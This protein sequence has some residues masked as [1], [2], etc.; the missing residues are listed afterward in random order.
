MARP[1]QRQLAEAV[2][3]RYPRS[4]ADQLGLG[5]PSGASGLFQLLTMALLMSARIRA[6]IA[7]EAA[8]ALAR[9]GWTTPEKLAEATFEERAGTLNRAGYAR[10]DERTS[11]MLGET[12]AL[13]LE[14]YGGDLRRLREAAKRDPSTERRLLKACK[15]VG[16]VGVDIFF[17]EAQRTWDELRP[18][19]DARA[20]RAAERLGLPGDAAAL[21]RLT[22][23]PGDLARLVSALVQADLEGDLE[24]IAGGAV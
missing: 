14:K 3:A 8:R 21:A 4:F 11:R 22:D 16:D 15:G 5:T 2:V 1:T 12:A 7:L 6:P 19:A 17:R 23:S 24:D 18:F 9:E 13:L 10:Y 20:L